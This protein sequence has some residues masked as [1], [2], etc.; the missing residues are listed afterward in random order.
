MILIGRIRESVGQHFSNRDRGRV[1]CRRPERRR[2]GIT[3]RQ[4]QIAQEREKG[5]QQG[6]MGGWK[7]KREVTDETIE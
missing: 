5:E 4:E 7:I 3:R 2:G 1:G 6:V